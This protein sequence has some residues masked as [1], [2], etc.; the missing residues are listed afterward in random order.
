M[1]KLSVIL[2]FVAMSFIVVAPAAADDQVIGTPVAQH[3]HNDLPTSPSCE[4]YLMEELFVL[5]VRDEHHV[6]MIAN[7]DSKIRD[8]EGDLMITTSKLWSAEWKIKVQAA[9][10]RHL[11]ALLGR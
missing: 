4:V 5:Q 6:D 11:R 10:I 3:V 7:Q 1:K 9:R 8:L 2:A